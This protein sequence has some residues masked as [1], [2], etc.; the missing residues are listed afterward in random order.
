MLRIKSVIVIGVVF[1]LVHIAGVNRG[2]LINAAYGRSS[3]AVYAAKVQRK[4]TLLSSGPAKSRAGKIRMASFFVNLAGQG[5][6]KYRKLVTGKVVSEDK[7]QITV[8]ELDQ[9]KIVVCTYSK[10]E[11][12]V[13]GTL[14]RKVMPETKY[15]EELAEYFSSRTGDFID[16][17]D[18]FIQAIRFYEKTKRIITETQG[19]DSEKVAAIEK[20]I[21]EL[22][23]GREIWT[24][25]TKDRAQL[26]QLEF[27]ATFDVRMKELVDEINR[28][29]DELYGIT[30]DIRNDYKNLK[31]LLSDFD[32]NVSLE[33]QDVKNRM[34]LNRNQIDDLSRRRWRTY[35]YYY[36]SSSSRYRY[37]NRNGRAD[38]NPNAR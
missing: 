37:K 22:K 38:L 29:S 18:D 1:A 16:D 14:S 30:E 2:C 8:A 20:N 10:K 3:D 12:V 31:G 19:I 21:Q 17:P 35:H 15:Y 26:K 24:R 28:T 6:T 27:E 36:P 23:A 32:R 33:L 4:G 11:Q 9:S 25:Q 13:G 5:K 34:A 7:N